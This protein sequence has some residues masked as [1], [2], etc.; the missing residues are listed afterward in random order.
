MGT[1][2]ENLVIETL[3]MKIKRRLSIAIFLLSIEFTSGQDQQGP[4]L[5][6]LNFL[7]NGLYRGELRNGK[8]HGQGTIVYDFHNQGGKFNYTG[9]WKDGKRD[10]IGITWYRNE[11][12]HQGF[13]ENDEAHGKGQKKNSVMVKFM[14]A[15]SIKVN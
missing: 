2:L 13:Y 3:N 5:N 7:H 4:S 9:Y 12:I 11:D 6:G 1:L 8:P 10:G 15:I 14:M